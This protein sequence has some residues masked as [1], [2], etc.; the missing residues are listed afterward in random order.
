[1]DTHAKNCSSS[2]YVMSLH[3]LLNTCREGGRE[4]APGFESPGDNLN[5][6]GMGR[7][8]RTGGLLRPRHVRPG[9]RTPFPHNCT[10]Q[11]LIVVVAR[12]LHHVPRLMLCEVREREVRC[13]VAH[14]AVRSCSGSRKGDAPAELNR[15]PRLIPSFTPRC[16]PQAVGRVAVGRYAPSCSRGHRGTRL[17]GRPANKEKW[18]S[19]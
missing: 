6:A 19:P 8:D 13:Y 2:M 7:Y 10:L 14:D 1:M 11:H 17:P 16:C 5:H 4:E 18:P 3:H 12:I 9:R 15:R